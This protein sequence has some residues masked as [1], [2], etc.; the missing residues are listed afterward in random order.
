MSPKLADLV[1]ELDLI[2]LAVSYGNSLPP[3]SS[4]WYKLADAFRIGVR[5][6][7]NIALD[8]GYHTFRLMEKKVT[9]KEAF[10]E[11]GE[12]KFLDALRATSLRAYGMNNAP[13]LQELKKILR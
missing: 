5:D 1:E 10:E 3:R 4:P 9:P 7:D 12:K 13:L 2:R 8:L 11:K 6:L